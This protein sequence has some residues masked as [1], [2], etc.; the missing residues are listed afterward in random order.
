MFLC[1]LQEV[2]KTKYSEAENDNNA[3]GDAQKHVPI[4]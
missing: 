3:V 2:C 4:W 1:V